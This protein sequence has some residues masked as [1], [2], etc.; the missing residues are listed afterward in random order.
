[1]VNFTILEK[2]WG[3]CGFS[4]KKIVSFVE[5]KIEPKFFKK[6]KK[7]KEKIDMLELVHLN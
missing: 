5:L 7:E 4:A 3:K 1:M 2:N 6:K